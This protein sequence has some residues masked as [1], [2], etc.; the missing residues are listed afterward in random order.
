MTVCSVSVIWYFHVKKVHPGNIVTTGV[1]PVLGAIG[2]AYVVWLLVDNLSFAGGAASGSVFFKLIPW[3]VGATFAVGLAAVL[4]LRSNRT[5]V[6]DA[7]GR[8]V[9]EE[10]A[11]RV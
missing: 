5:D 8:T 4:W 9:L 6:Y 2:M 3:I 7:I 11:E 10:S 1:I